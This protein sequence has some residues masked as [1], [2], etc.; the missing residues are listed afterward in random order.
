[1]FNFF[2]KPK[3]AEETFSQKYVSAS[4]ELPLEDK[5]ILLEAA[6]GKNINGNMFALLRELKTKEKWSSYTVYFVVTRET[7]DSAKARFSHYGFKD[8]KLLIRDTPAYAKVLAVAKYLFTDNSF[9]IYFNKRP[10]QICVNTW[11]GTPIKYLGLSDIDNAISL[12]NL[13][14][15]F[16][17]SDYMLFPNSFTMDVFTRDYCLENIFTGHNLL[18]DYPRNQALLR[19]EDGEKLKEKLGLSQK[20]VIAYMPTWRGSG[21][22]ADKNIQQLILVRFFDELDTL[23][24][25]NQV[26]YV[27]LHF[28]V[29][30]IIDLSGYKHIKAF[31]EEYETY[32]F[33]SLCDCL[34]TDYSSVMFDFAATAKKILI[35]A[36]DLEEYVENKGLYFPITDLPFPISKNTEELAN[37]INQSFSMSDEYEAFIQRFAKYRSPNSSSNLLNLVIN[38]EEYPSSIMEILPPKHNGKPNLLLHCGRPTNIIAKYKIYE[39]IEGLKAENI[40]EENNIIIS[41]EGGM[42]PETIEFIKGLP[43]KTNVISL[44]RAHHLSLEEEQILNQF[45]DQKLKPDLYY[46]HL[47]S[48]FQRE[49]NRFFYNFKIDK[50]IYYML[51]NPLNYYVLSHFDCK[52]T[53]YIQNP[54]CIGIRQNTPEMRAV[55]EDAEKTFHK[56]INHEEI[57]LDENK[58]DYSSVKPERMF[59]SSF[60]FTNLFTVSYNTP[61]SINLMAI[62]KVTTTLDINFKEAVIYVEDQP[63][64]AFFLLE[65]GIRSKDGELYNF[66]KFKIPNESLEN[67]RL[68]NKVRI[69]IVSP[70]LAKNLH[71]KTGKVYGFNNR[72]IYSLK[73]SKGPFLKFGEYK[74]IKSS[75]TTA[76]FRSVKANYL[77]LMVRKTN[78]TDFLINRI[79]LT[80][81]FI[82]SKLMGPDKSILLFE[83]ETSR[84]EESASVVYERLIDDGYSNAYFILDKSY[85]H[86]DKI[87][88]KYLEN[89]IW[90]NSF[91]HYYH[92][93]RSN[94]FISSEVLP[95]VVDL[96][97]VNKRA[98][99]KLNSSNINYVFLQHGVMYMISLDSPS[100]KFFLKSDFFRNKKAN[101]KI[102]VSSD[103]EAEHFVTRGGYSPNDLYKTG[104][105]KL[106]KSRLDRNA[107]KIAIMPTW[108]PWEYN[109]ARADCTATGYFKALETIAR[110]VPNHLKDKVIILPHPLVS[111]AMRNADSPI[112]KYIVEKDV[113]YD[114]VLYNT[115]LLITDY[116]SI[117]YDAFY[118]GSQVIFYWEEK[119]ETVAK[120]G[121]G[122]TLLLDESNIF[123]NICMNPEELTK[124]IEN[125]YNSPIYHEFNNNYSRIVEFRDG[126]N[127]DRLVEFLKRDGI[128]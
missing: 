86:I 23:L 114:D 72:I 52:K 111:E 28:L 4:K 108:R 124:T 2:S 10:G 22:T 17:A 14:K 19:P 75:Q 104:L 128:I 95:H 12:T 49:N 44:P 92:F 74:V 54:V 100:R 61:G 106:D 55:I 38:Q 43:I 115:R 57:I 62:C 36:Y 16:Y 39:F 82:L 67:F 122:T 29:G 11:H 3:I 13:Q 32:D 97:I 89:I 80:A 125:D 35:Y 78:K 121:L 51:G 27:N 8:V 107:D 31:P 1:M 73:D 96:R 117:A 90:K 37:H 120:Y 18:A 102:V 70:N 85:P 94:N 105:P 68:Y 59:N 65:K 84:Y 26:F 9:P 25:D 42:I 118:R 33:L 48:A 76:I 99:R 119:E 91:K 15:N 98:V 50:L 34:V 64:K 83:K 77:S 46:K 66:Y 6:Q 88:T 123:G 24:N 5:Q 112:A 40:T 21:R 71:S 20:N 45:K 126:K 56:V 101:F 69:S 127:T 41:F 81:A 93:F 103:L 110:S 58:Y 53:L 30:S 116:S 113:K 7:R 87:E 63:F 60:L 109:Q 47:N 79:K